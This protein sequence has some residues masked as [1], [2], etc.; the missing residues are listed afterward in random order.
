M[1][2]KIEKVIPKRL[3]IY[4]WKSLPKSS[5]N[6]EENYRFAE[7][8]HNKIEEEYPGLSRGVLVKNNEYKQNTYNQ[9]LFGS[10]VLLEIGGFENT[11]Q[12]EYRTADV[13]AEIIQDILKGD[14]K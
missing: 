9:E 10:S 5:I 13:L 8:L 3:A 6:Y 14:N 4:L 1:S 11:L 12:E 2:S 7:L